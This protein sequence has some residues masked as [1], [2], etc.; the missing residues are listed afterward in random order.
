MSIMEKSVEAFQS[1]S[2][3][4]WSQNDPKLRFHHESFQ[5]VD[6]FIFCVFKNIFNLIQPNNNFYSIKSTISAI[7]IHLTSL[8]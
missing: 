1:F 3:K 6:W 2:K 5:T 4:A 8:Y 7:P